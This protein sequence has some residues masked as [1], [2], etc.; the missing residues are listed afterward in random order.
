MDAI[1]FHPETS[2]R[3]ALI[4]ALGTY[5]PE[6]ISPGEREELVA[7][8]LDLYKNDPDSGIHA[9][10][11]WALRQWN[12]Q[13][14]LKDAE[15]GLPNLKDRGD[16]R[17]FVNSKGQTFALIEGPV[18]FT[19]GSP[20]GEPDRDSGEAAHRRQIPRNFAIAVKEVSVRQYQ[21]FLRQ[22]A[23][24]EFGLDR[25][26]LD[27]YS[28][29]ADGPMIAVTWF[30][31][32]AYCNWLSR[33]EGLSE[34]YEPNDEKQYAVGMTI[35]ADA[36]RRGGYRLPTEAEWDYA[37]RA[38]TVTS[39]YHGFSL[40]LLPQYARYTGS[41]AEHAWPGGSLL[42][43]DL[44][45]FDMLGNVFEWC[46]DSS[47]RYQTGGGRG[48]AEQYEISSPVAIAEPRVLRGAAFDYRPADLRSAYRGWLPPAVR[49]FSI[50]FRLARTCD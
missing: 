13:A 29:D 3:R 37:C 40:S 43:N 44:G 38:G 4:Q 17:W 35:R 46:N 42:A 39:R 19:M 26:Y 1:L 33:K 32:A 22:N 28:P 14:K 41:S 49:R 2:A 27:K 21:E 36:L 34:C 8:L 6:A 20:P 5:G 11:E 30:G 15:A 12:E 23:N 24:P 50:G 16:R 18:E 48:S 47:Y 9:A 10:A 7:S 25:S 45:L 31:A